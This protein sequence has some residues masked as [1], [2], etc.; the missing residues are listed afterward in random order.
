MSFLYAGIAFGVLIAFHEFGHMWV[1]KR[2]GMR[3][4]RFSI[5]FGPVIFSRKVGETEY[6]V[7]AVPLGGYVTIAGMSPEDEVDPAD[8]HSYANRPAWARL[9]AIA[10]GPV[11]NYV[12]AFVI[13]VP[14]L[15]FAN[16]ATDTST[17]KVGDVVPGE[18]A[19]TAGLQV[20]DDLR[21]VGHTPLTDFDSIRAAINAEAKA[22]PGEA[23]PIALMRGGQPMVVA[24][25][26]RE[27]AGAWRIGIG[28]WQKVEPGLPLLQAVPQALRNIWDANLMSLNVLGKLFT[29]GAK[30]SDLSGPIGMITTTAA[31]AKKGFLDYVKTVWGLS[32]AIG[33][34][35]LL[36]IP[37]LDGGRGVFLLYEVVARRRVN[38]RVEGF[39][40]AAGLVALLA[41]ILFVSYGDIMRRIKGG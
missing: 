3:V 9:L 5:G 7:S 33:F 39:I 8:P 28:P 37:A 12:L 18:A 36:P 27:V 32:V 30:V 17:S 22:R 40:H 23:I 2:L 26:P 1:A 20:G 14:L 19:A 6:A 24:V 41:L 21:A 34:F 4:D 13:G 11:A 10:A 35:N 31:Q 25:K 38:Q 15:L 16:M 29:G